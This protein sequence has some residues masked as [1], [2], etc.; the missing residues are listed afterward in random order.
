MRSGGR[1]HVHDDRAGAAATG[2]ESARVDALARLPQ[3]LGRR[4]ARDESRVGDLA[5]QAQ[6]V[7][8]DGTDS[9]HATHPGAVD[10]PPGAVP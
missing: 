3:G 5:G 7:R 4:P 2:G 8:S 10:L 6:G 9:R 1:Q